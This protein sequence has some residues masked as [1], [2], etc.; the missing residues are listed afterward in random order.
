[1]SFSPAA[2]RNAPSVR[3]ELGALNSAAFD[4]KLGGHV[5]SVCSDV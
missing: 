3:R 4:A 5:S 1:M 2:T